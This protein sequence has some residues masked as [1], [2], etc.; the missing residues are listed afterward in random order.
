MKLQIV[1]LPPTSCDLGWL[2]N[3]FDPQFP[4]LKNGVNK[5]NMGLSV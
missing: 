3:I 5:N 2:W 1:T 4:H